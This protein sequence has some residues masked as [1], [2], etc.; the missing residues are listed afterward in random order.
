MQS[1]AVEKIRIIFFPLK[2]DSSQGLP[3][4]APG[5]RQG[6]SRRRPTIIERDA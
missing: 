6:W 1:N 2:Y 4:P 3:L 5:Q